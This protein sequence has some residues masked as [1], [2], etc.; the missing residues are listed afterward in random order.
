MRFPAIVFFYRALTVCN[1]CRV[2]QFVPLYGGAIEYFPTK[3]PDTT[4]S[5]TTFREIIIAIDAG[6]AGPRRSHL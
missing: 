4:S 6:S 3:S 2:V 5:P 1:A